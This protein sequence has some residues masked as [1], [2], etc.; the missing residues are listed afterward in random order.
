MA[1][2]DISASNRAMT[3]WLYQVQPDTPELTF[4][5][6]LNE[7]GSEFLY[8]APLCAAPM[9]MMPAKQFWAL[10]KENGYINGW[11]K[12]QEELAQKRAALQGD[13][14]WQSY[15]NR[16]LYNS[17]TSLGE[18]IPTIDSS[19]DQSSLSGKKL[20]KYNNNKLISQCYDEAKQI[21]EETK[22]MLEEAKANGRKLTKEQL[23]EQFEKINKAMRKGDISVYNLQK[24]GLIQPTSWYGRAKKFI[25]GK[26]GITALEG[27]M[28]KTVKG[29][30]A[31]RL[32]SKCVKGSGIMAVVE[33]ACEIPDIINAYQIDKAERAAGR[34]SNRG[35]K[36]LAKSAVKV[37]ASVLGYAA[38]S[39]L[40]GAA[41]GAA[42]GSVVP[43]VG[44]I[45]GFVGGLIGGFVAGWLAGK[46]TDAV[47]GEKNSLD[48]SEAQLYAEEQNEVAKKEAEKTARLAD[49]ST[50][51]QDELLVT[52]EQAINEGNTPPEEVL[53][54]YQYMLSERKEAIESESGYNRPYDYIEAIQNI[55]VM[56]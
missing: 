54:A 45:V 24:R 11:K 52:I 17:I 46:A 7:K 20:I 10:K 56:A 38:G 37:G 6:K 34:E 43:V 47:L 48:K 8:G 1:N 27:K 32:A 40:A 51:N 22:Q 4:A 35:N 39:A 25:K 14:I 12:M 49:L 5:D 31:L 21:I 26:T 23:K 3:N 9:L 55:S 30:S 53:E 13:N 28:L 2:T 33:G 19:I 16:K 41:V 29:A 15:G 44:N 36:Q 50:K 42:V 18:G